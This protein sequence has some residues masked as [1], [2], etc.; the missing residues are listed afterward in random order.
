[1]GNYL[2][3][4]YAHSNI[5]HVISKLTQSFARKNNGNS[6]LCQVLQILTLE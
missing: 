1:M 2:R 4:N 3:M 6:T 5:I